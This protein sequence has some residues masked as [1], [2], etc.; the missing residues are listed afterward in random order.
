MPRAGRRPD[1][2]P[3]MTAATDDNQLV[4]IDL[5]MTGLE[6]DRDVIVEIACIVT[7]SDL[8]ASTTASRSSCTPTTTCSRRWAT[9]STKMHTKSGLLPGIER[10][11]V[12]VA[13]AAQQP[14]S[15]TYAGT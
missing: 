1:N 2:V 6:I 4:W 11:D 5:E 14:C 3:G 8:H 10:S 7:D 15:T 9:S 13:E 12:T